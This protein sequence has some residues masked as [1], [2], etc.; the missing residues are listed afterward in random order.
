[1]ESNN[2]YFNRPLCEFEINDMGIAKFIRF[3]ILL[4]RRESS[5]KF[6][7][8][9]Y[10]DIK[11]I[12]AQTKENYLNIIAYANSEEKMAFALVIIHICGKYSIDFKSDEEL[13]EQLMRELHN[14]NYDVITI[15]ILGMKSD[16]ILKILKSITHVELATQKEMRDELISYSEFFNV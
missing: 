16:K 3:L 8:P 4:I 11:S 9:Y 12:L 14:T 10:L 1:M 13:Q 5:I 7:N 15:V 2:L 6:Y